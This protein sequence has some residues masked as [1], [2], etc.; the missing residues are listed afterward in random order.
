MAGPEG[1]GVA[2][3]GAV[4]GAVVV[5]V[6]VVAGERCGCGERGSPRR[7]G[8]DAGCWTMMVMDAA[9]ETWAG[10]DWAAGRRRQ[11]RPS[12][13]SQGGQQFVPALAA[14]QGRARRKTHAP[15]QGRHVPSPV[16][17]IDYLI[18]PGMLCA[19]CS[20]PWGRPLL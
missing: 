3:A 7:V 13:A 18:R 2:W 9:G 6:V 5:V 11:A 17:N 10:G 20:S 1:A 14:K 19:S 8:P 16:G 15:W 12:R 4:G